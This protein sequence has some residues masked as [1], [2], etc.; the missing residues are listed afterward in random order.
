[1][2]RKRT[3]WSGLWETV[4]VGAT[5][6]QTFGP[7]SNNTIVF[8][9]SMTPAMMLKCNGNFD[10]C[11]RGGKSNFDGKRTKRRC[12]GKLYPNWSIGQ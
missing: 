7:M 10:H 9:R 1:M 3:M 8:A 11:N 12:K 2:M 6:R 5:T 4:A